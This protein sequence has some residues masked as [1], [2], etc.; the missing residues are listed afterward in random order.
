MRRVLLLGLLALLVAPLAI[1][2]PLAVETYTLPNGFTVMLNP[3][4]TATEVSGAVMVKAGGKNDPADATGIAHYLEHLLFKGTQEMGTSDYEAEKVHL[5]RIVE[6]YDEAAATTD[7][8]ARQA[9]YTEINQ[10]AL[11]ASEYGM[12]NEFDKLLKSLGS[13]GIN[14]F[15]S[16][17]I[18]FY[19]NNFPAHELPRWLDLYSHRF[20]NPVFRSFQ[21]ELEVVYEEK[22]RSMDAFQNRLIETFNAEVFKGHPYG[23]QLILGTIEHLKNPSLTKMYEFFKTYYVAN[24]MALIL[25]GNFDPETAKPL[26]AEKFGDWRTGEVPEYPDYPKRRFEKKQ[27][28][29]VRLTPIAVSLMGFK[30]VNDTHPDRFGLD[31]VAAMLSNSAS[32]GFL[33]EI[34]LEGKVLQA[35]MFNNSMQDDGVSIVIVVPKPVVQSF[36]AAEKLVLAAIEKVQ[37]GEFTDEDLAAVKSTLYK[38]FQSSLESVDNRAVQMG[39]CFSRGLSWDD[40]LKYPEMVASITREDVMRLAEQYY[41]DN[42]FAMYSKTGFP[43]KEELEKPSYEPVTTDQNAESGYARAFA[44]MEPALPEATFV[45]LAKDVTRMELEGGNK[46]F[47]TE[48]PINDI[49]SLEMEFQVGTRTLP[50]LEPIADVLNLAGTSEYS[51]TELKK[52]FASLGA[53]FYFSVSRNYF[54]LSV[55]GIEENLAPTLAL[56]NQLLT[57]TEIPQDAIKTTAEGIE[58]NRE[59]ESSTPDAM[60]SVLFQYG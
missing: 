34:S 12:P 36:K 47:W 31:V 51:A 48:N 16:S 27:T 15:T 58:T 8:E 40:Y 11:A 39:F 28:L 1:A 32:S 23:D 52:Q 5:D 26:I 25:S 7:P 4:A 35:G 24:N 38:D 13:T 9:L 43:K 6:L 2:Q 53:S 30:T 17:D 3:D 45:D 10:E 49:F 50:S 29:D 37:E 59:V 56:V 55:D 21:S 46:L 54:T 22:N 33:D 44:S 60:G 42:Y 19:Y 57:D 18:T 20:E 14:A 41:G